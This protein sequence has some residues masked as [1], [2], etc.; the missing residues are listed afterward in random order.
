MCVH[1]YLH[2]CI[3]IHIIICNEVF[4]ML[5]YDV[6]RHC[7]ETCIFY[8]LCLDIN[9][10]YSGSIQALICTCVCMCVCIAPAD[11]RTTMKSVACVS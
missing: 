7:K 2:V 5:C 1:I 11:E 4:F 3:C 10:L 8:L 6:L 9:R